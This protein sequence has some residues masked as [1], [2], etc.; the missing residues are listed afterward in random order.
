MPPAM[1]LYP[2]EVQMAFFIYS[3]LQ[4]TFDGM[5]GY[6]L[7]K[8]LSG[9]GDLLDI[10]NIEDKQTVVYFIKVIDA[11][12]GASINEEVNRKQKAAKRKK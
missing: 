5:S 8:R 9:L 1:E 2:Y 3:L 6:Y 4:D 10:Y 7:G 11:E 12:R